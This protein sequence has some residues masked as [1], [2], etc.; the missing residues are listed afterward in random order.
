MDIL[1][2][3]L[4]AIVCALLVLIILVQKPKGQGLGSS[5]GGGSANLL[6]GVQKTNKFLDQATW[7]LAIALLV[8]VL[9][10]NVGVVGDTQGPQVQEAPDSQID[11]QLNED[12]SIPFQ[13]LPQGATGG[14]IEQQIDPVEE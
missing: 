4:I 12:N 13:S 10:T 11:D 1:L 9:I 2:A 8:L 6:G 5:F 14:A 3:V 7:G